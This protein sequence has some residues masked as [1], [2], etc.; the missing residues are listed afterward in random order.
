M[1]LNRVRAVGDLIVHVQHISSDGDDVFM[2]PG[3]EGV[4]IHGLVSPGAGEVVVTKAHP[5]AFRET[6]LASI[7][8]DAGIDQLVML[9]MMTSMCV[10]AT[11]RAAADAGFKVTVVADA[12]ASP[13]LNFGQRS[14]AA[15]DVQAAF[16]AAL[17]GTYADIIFS[18]TF[19]T[20]PTPSA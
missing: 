14:V 3:T 15:A 1:V 6:E 7:L 2:R 17:D 11:V 19:S 13:D 18:E 20:S 5:N 10:D 12:C 16:L 4:E 9:G 8:S